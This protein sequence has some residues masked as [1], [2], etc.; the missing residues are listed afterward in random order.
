MEKLLFGLKKVNRSGPLPYYYQ[1]A[2]SLQEFI[3][4]KLK[5]KT[6]LPSEEYLA[7]Y[8]Q[9]T[10]P[11]I[12]K[13]MDLLVKKSL[14]QR[15]RGK[16]TFVAGK[17]VE[18]PLI[19]EPISFGEAL[20]KSGINSS[21]EV[22]ELRKIKA[23]EPVSRWLSVEMGTALVYLERLRHIDNE[24]FLLVKSYLPYDPFPDVLRTDFTRQSLF[25]TLSRKY[26][27]D[28]TKIDRY[29]RIVKASEDEAGSLKTSIGDGL[30]QMEGVAFSQQGKKV[31]YFDIKMKGD[32]I[33]FFT[34]LHSRRV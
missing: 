13:A 4:K 14:V 15:N 27:T 32:K 18:L 34:T 33:V 10:R 7:G 22:L 29:M 6:K 9:L 19:Y 2:Q 23:K 8:F 28:V 1:V 16:G 5:P 12:H 20:R 26:H 24:P 31:E 17:T 25:S 30:L 21:V 3:E 11:T